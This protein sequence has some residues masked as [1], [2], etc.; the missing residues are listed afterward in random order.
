M[1]D[2]EFGLW[3][4]HVANVLEDFHGAMDYDATAD[5]AANLL[6]TY[7]RAGPLV[8]LAAG[9]AR[10]P[11]IPVARYVTESMTPTDAGRRW[12]DQLEA[13]EQSL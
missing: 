12:A 3:V 1:T 2:P 10:R 9:Q 13:E 8:H 6:R 7:L 4:A 11:E 5:H